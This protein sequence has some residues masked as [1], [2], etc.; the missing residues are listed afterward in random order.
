MGRFGF[1]IEGPRDIDSRRNVVVDIEVVAM[2]SGGAL[3]H[4]QVEVVRILLSRVPL[5]LMKRGGIA[6]AAIAIPP[7]MGFPA[8]THNQA[9]AFNTGRGAHDDPAGDAVAGGD[10]GGWHR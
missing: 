6:L 1:G 10:R 3:G 4:E 8:G 9:I 7:P 5:A 2:V